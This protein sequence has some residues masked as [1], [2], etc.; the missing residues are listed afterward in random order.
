MKGGL[1]HAPAPLIDDV[2]NLSASED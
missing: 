1:N 2:G